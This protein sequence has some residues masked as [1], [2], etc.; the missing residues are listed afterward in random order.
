MRGSSRSRAHAAASSVAPAVSNAVAG[1]HD[2]QPNA[3]VNGESA[4][5]SSMKRMPSSPR[6]FAISC[7]SL[8]L[9]TVPCRMA[10]RAN[11]HGGSMLLSTWTCASTNPGTR[12]PGASSISAGPM[13]AMRPSRT[14]TVAGRTVSA[15]TSATRCVSENSIPRSVSRSGPSTVCVEATS[16]T[17]GVGS[18]S[19]GR[20]SKEGLE[21]GSRGRVSRQGLEAAPRH[22]AES[23][24]RVA[25]TG[26]GP[27]CEVRP[28]APRHCAAGFAGARPVGAGGAFD[29]SGTAGSTRN[30]IMS[31]M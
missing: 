27:R 28:R 22:L 31:L 29:G 5:S 14:T 23:W 6:T 21:A 7:G 1:T 24:N 9:A 16:R 30:F 19:R 15:T 2:G 20:V 17:R 18:R 8:T 13:R 12:T 26:D 10:T 25:A 3:K 11:S 4:A